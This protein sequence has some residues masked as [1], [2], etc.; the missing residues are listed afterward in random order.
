MVE[1]TTASGDGDTATIELQGEC[2]AGDNV[3]AVG[4]DIRPGRRLL[5]PGVRLRAAEIAVLATFGITRVPVFRRPRVHVVSTGDEVV[6]PDRQPSAGKLRDCN[7]YALAAGVVEAGG[8]PH[9]HAIVPDDAEALTREIRR[10]LEAGAD[11]VL[12]SGGSSMGGSD[13]TAD[14]LAALGPPGV[15]LHGIDVRPGKP[16]IV[17]AVGDTPLIGMPGYPVSSMVIFHRFVRPLLWALG[18]LDPPPP[19]W[20]PV[21]RGPL[22]AP[23]RSRAGREDY[24]RVYVA[25]DGT[26][27]PLPGGS[28]SLTSLL[29]AHGVVI[30]PAESDGLAAGAPVDVLAL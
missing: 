30:V 27:R 21:A 2:G 9:L 17:A 3:Q 23:I 25:D 28:A 10:A 26:V 22:A 11:V 24:V 19:A 8:T 14:S 4:D 1:R 20:P 13:L 6:P 7:S 12:L 5:E 18:G 29:G 15:L 16:T